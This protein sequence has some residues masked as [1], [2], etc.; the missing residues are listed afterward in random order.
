[1][2]E[3]PS[4]RSGFGDE[5]ARHAEPDAP[6][7]GDRIGSL[8]GASVQFDRRR[9]GQVIVGVLVC[10]L[11]VLI[12]VFTVAGVH[13][14]GQTDELHE[15]G[16]PVTVTVTGCLGLLGG[17]GSNAAGYS[18]HG[19]YVLDGRRNTVSLPGT[20][21]HRPGSTIPSLAVPDDPALVSPDSV[22]DHQHSSAGVFVLPAVLGAILLALIGVIAW[23]YRARSRIERAGTV[24]EAPT[25]RTSS[26]SS[27]DDG[28][29]VGGV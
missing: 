6:G 21:F 22:I 3:P 4:H 9:A 28:A 26:G 27:P 29:Y 5:P 14:N 16:V 1:M 15:H 7:A 17:S 12:V 25:A 11:V 20:L 13:S 19:T 24:S 10:T 23:R 8:R 18:C 2:T